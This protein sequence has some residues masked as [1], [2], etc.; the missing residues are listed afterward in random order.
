MFEGTTVALVTPFDNG[1]IDWK[2]LEKLLDFHLEKGTDVI[3]PC[4]TTGESATLTHEEH[5]EVIKFVVERVGKRRKVLAGTGSNSTEEALELSLFAQEVGADGVLLIT[6]YYNKPTQRGLYLHFERIARQ[7][8]IPVVLYNVP[9]RTGVNLEFST[10]KDLSRV[11]N[12]VAVKEASGNLDQIMRIIS[13]ESITVLSGDDSLTFPIIALGGKGVVSVA[14]N[15]VPQEIKEMVDLALEGKWEEARKIHYR[16][17]PLFKV[18]FIETNPIPV[19]TALGILGM[20]KEEFRL[21]LAPMKEE[22]RKELI[23]VM[24]LLNL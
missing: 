20:I 21:P 11:P 15:L 2:T 23:R 13:L 8:S 10:V 6:P 18:L 7:L 3:L 24:K 1:K 4:G 12:I 5:R 14:A 19:K 9:S 16:L 17:Y 22:N